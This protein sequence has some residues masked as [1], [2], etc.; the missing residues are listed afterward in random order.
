MIFAQVPAPPDFVWKE[1]FALGLGG[2]LA[3]CTFMLL[4][5][6]ICNIV[7]KQLTDWREDLAAARKEFLAEINLDRHEFVMALNQHGERF[8]RIAD[9]VTDEIKENSAAIRHLQSRDKP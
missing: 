5:H 1:A 3:V 4:Y 7:P 6:V 2:V 9:K 8:E